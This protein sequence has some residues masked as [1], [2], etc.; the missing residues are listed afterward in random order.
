VPENIGKTLA[1]LLQESK[2]SRK[3]IDKVWDQQL[4]WFRGEQE[5]EDVMPGELTTATNFLF[6]MVQ[7]EVPMLSNNIP[8]ISVKHVDDPNDL[9]GELITELILRIFQRND[10]HLRL[11]EF[12]T[13]GLIFGRSFFKPTWSPRLR[14][15][16]G[17]VKVEV[18]DTRNIFLEPGKLWLP[19]MN[20]IFEARPINKLSL[21]RMY[22]DKKAKIDKLFEKETTN[23]PA[24]PEYAADA[25]PGRHVTAPGAAIDT[26]TQSYVED[27]V[28]GK[29]RD[30]PAIEFVDGWFCDERTIGDLKRVF[31]LQIKAPDEQPAFPRGRL[32]Q[33]AGNDVFQD[34]PNPF[35]AFP[36]IDYMNYFIPG[37]QWW[38]SDLEQAMP[39][40]EQY[41]IRSNQIFQILNYHANPW[42]FYDSTSGLDPSELT[43][44]P[45]DWTGVTDINGI[46][47]EASPPIHSG[48]FESLMMLKANLEDMFGVPDPLRGN[49]PGQVRSGFGIEQLIESAQ[50]RLQLKSRF[51]EAAIKD[52]SAYL[53]SMLGAFYI[54][55]VH[56]DKDGT[57]Q[58]DLTGIH[59]DDY[60]ITIKAGVNMPSSSFLEE[61]RIKWW[62]ERGIVD[63]QFI[64]DH[65]SIRDKQ[66]LTERMRPLWDMKRQALMAPPQQPIPGGA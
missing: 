10:L 53:I 46:R 49:A 51:L 38:M 39:L 8:E 24:Y 66:E 44:N 27:V 11:V 23:D 19:D 37:E 14:K 13:Y 17:D 21:Y 31:D 63:E 22:P 42:K 64:V 33:F 40:Q 61:Q 55:G 30:K 45:M 62:Y 52:L 1:V 3:S 47:I 7:T 50:I 25:G 16:L 18:P 32:V 12:V 6:A 4:K 2:D 36:Y 34:R 9:S 15:G 54:R 35:P 57:G 28:Q 29:R 43:N 20:Y 58:I 60:D 65:S 56:Y 5:M 48:T 26:S 41:N 59:P